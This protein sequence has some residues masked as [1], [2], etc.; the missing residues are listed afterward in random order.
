MRRTSPYI[1]ILLFISGCSGGGDEG[2]NECAGDRPA[3]A[4]ECFKGYFFAEC[5]G[6][7][8]ARLACSDS[9]G[10]Y[11]FASDCA[12]VG[13]VASDCPVDDICCHAGW[14]FADT[15]AFVDGTVRDLSWKIAALGRSTWDRS[16]SVVLPVGVDPTLT[17]SSTVNC[18]G[19]PSD[20]GYTPCGATDL[21][22][23]VTAGDTLVIKSGESPHPRSGWEAWIEIVPDAAGMPRARMCKY[24]FTDVVGTSCQG[25]GASCASSGTIT[26]NQWPFN[27]ANLVVAV[28]VSF[29]NGLAITGLLA[30]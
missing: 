1:L 9:D 5:G 2:L 7:G 11:W 18:T 22:V 19:G 24:F 23:S 20:P 4:T 25:F 12:P 14:P 26:V 15:Q 10:C 17:G 16:R 30:Q 27:G 6:T 29:D 28:D 3:A 13:F 8:S 21:L